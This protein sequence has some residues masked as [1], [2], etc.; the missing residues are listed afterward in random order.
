MAESPEHQFISETF[1]ATLS[2]F[3]RSRLYA[4]REGERKKFDFSC[5]LAETWEYLLD[6]QT[7]WKHS[8]G[9]DK[10]LR[11]LLL[12]SDAQL[13][14]Y[15]ARDTTKHRAT[16]VETARDYRAAGHESALRRLKVFWIPADFDADSERQRVI[17]EEQMQQEIIEDVLFNTIFG[18]LSK[19]RVR[20]VILGSGAVGLELAVLHA[21]ATEGFLNF[22]S[23]KSSVPASPSTL[24]DR[25]QR[26]Q[27]SGLLLQPRTG[28]QEYFVSPAGR[29][30]LRICAQLSSLREPVI[31][32]KEPS[33]VLSPELVDI[34]GLLGLEAPTDFHQYP[35]YTT[36][37]LQGTTPRAMFDLLFSKVF[38]A[39]ER[40]GTAWINQDFQAHKYER[41]RAYWMYLF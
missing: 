30:F 1:L 15:I 12:S 35:K 29:A 18:G 31:E 8:E 25:V 24:R 22:P 17:V 27:M 3:S 41:D 9:V 38:M 5:V 39:E 34:L 4:Y 14:V 7:L 11:T 23:L 16:F 32:K 33:E 10:D 13:S 37:W 26:L 36:E 28:G 40:W 21:I 2:G 20:P 6:G 19:E